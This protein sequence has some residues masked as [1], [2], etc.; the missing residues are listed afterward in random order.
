MNKRNLK[1]FLVSMMTITILCTMSVSMIYATEGELNGVGSGSSNTTEVVVTPAPE[2]APVAT[3]APVQATQPVVDN[4]QTNNGNVATPII[5]NSTQNSQEVMNNAEAIGGLFTQA[6]PDAEDIEAANTFIA[7]L[8]NIA[9]KVM[10]VILGIT[11]LLMMFTTI[12]DLLYIAFPPVRDYLD[13][14]RMGVANMMGGARGSRGMG[15]SRYGGMG[16]YGGGMGGY[17][18]GMGMGGYGGGMGM[19]GMG[20]G[21]MG[22]MGAT[23]PQQQ[24]VGGGLSAVGRWVSD[25]AIAACMTSQGGGME[26]QMG[27]G[28]T[29]VKSMIFTY[30]KKR[31]V[32]LILFGICVILFT[33]TVFTDLGVRLGTWGLKLIMGFGA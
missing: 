12:L 16:R 30:M 17:G 8:A 10:A 25:E 21:G 18:G 33:S 27:M 31:M 24:P 13:G 22:G 6:G 26:G 23:G 2:Q 7:P 9:N 32:F 28:G 1:K 19:G 15:G 4:T 11:S 3:Q 14:G 5:P 29:T 20:M